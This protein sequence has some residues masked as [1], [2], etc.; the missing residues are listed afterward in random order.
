MRSLWAWLT[1]PNFKH[2]QK[3]GSEDVSKQEGSKESV[4]TWKQQH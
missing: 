1:W 3:H 2:V 4:E